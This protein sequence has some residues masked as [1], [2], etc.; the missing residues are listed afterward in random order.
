MFFIP[1]WWNVWGLRNYQFILFWTKVLTSLDLRKF[2]SILSKKKVVPSII[3]WL[4]II[5]II[6]W[7]FST[8]D[9]TLVYLGYCI[10]QGGKI[11]V[12]IAMSAQYIQHFYCQ[13][14][15]FKYSFSSY[16]YIIDA[17]FALWSLLWMCFFKCCGCEYDL[18]QDSHL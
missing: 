2:H 1:P 10:I 12:N 4:V 6:N 14:L 11:C 9:L 18:L 3:F 15:D 7:F 17:S 5:I 16:H 8:S 13:N